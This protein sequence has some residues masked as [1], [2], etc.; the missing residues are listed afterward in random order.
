MV[1]CRTLLPFCHRV[2]AKSDVGVK[3][4]FN[5]SFSPSRHPRSFHR[6]A[7]NS[8]KHFEMK[9]E[10]QSWASTFISLVY[11]SI[12]IN[13]FAV[14]EKFLVLIRM[15]SVI[16]SIGLGNQIEG[17]LSFPGM[18]LLRDPCSLQR[19]LKQRDSTPEWNP[20]RR[21]AVTVF[22]FYRL[23][24]LTLLKKWGNEGNEPT[25]ATSA[26]FSSVVMMTN[27]QKKKN[28]NK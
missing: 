10:T 13:V 21:I 23:L 4:L 17:Y 12:D 26:I 24:C 7:V 20:V 18:L 19:E 27:N 16:Q 5:G 3:F 28:Q 22:P 1:N 25:S 8:G 2:A 11:R 14:C 15:W 9:D 6:P